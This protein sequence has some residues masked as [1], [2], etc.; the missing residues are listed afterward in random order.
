MLSIAKIALN[1][2][3]PLTFVPYTI[4][5]SHSKIKVKFFVTLS[6]ICIYSNNTVLLW[7]WHHMMSCNSIML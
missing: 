3:V 7:S 2:I 5:N 1:M 6:L 4:I